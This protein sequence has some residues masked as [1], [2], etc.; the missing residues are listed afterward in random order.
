VTWDDGGIRPV[1]FAALGQRYRR[2][3]LADLPAEGAMAGSL[4]RW[5]QLSPVVACAH[6]QQLEV[7]D[8]FK[9]LAAAQQV[10]GWTTLS[11]RVIDVDERTAKA[12]ILGLN[13]GQRPVRELEEA[14]IVQ[15]LVRDDGLTQVEAGQ[16][17]GQH[18]SWVCRR[19]ALLEKLSVGVKEDL[20]LGLLGPALAR[21]LTRLPAGNQQAVLSLTRR[22]TLTAQEVSGVIELL[23]GASP[24]QA[25][26]V[27]EKPREA[28]AQARGLPTALR[29][30]RLSRA[31]NWLA[32]QLTQALEALVRMENWLRTP[33]ERELTER[34]REI[35]QPL[36]ARLGD[37]A[38][39]VAEQVLGPVRGLDW[40]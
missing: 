36:L 19:L 23:Q 29:D 2:Y 11:V 38:S 3:R 26:F 5:G 18:K 17:L 10:A 28:L 24:E 22:Q 30:P 40:R 13:R 27:L 1:A 6:G 16:L 25:A 15:A 35:V 9:R 21:Q 4:R 20:R 14:W 37:E 12:A 7:L 32:R 8:G 33:G 39:V 31:G 34:D